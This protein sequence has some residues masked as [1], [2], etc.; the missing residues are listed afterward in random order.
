MSKENKTKSKSWINRFIRTWVFK[1]YSLNFEK[2]R[3]KIFIKFINPQIE[4]KILD[5][6]GSDGRRMIFLASDYKSIVI[7]D[8]S[9]KA[10]IK[11]KETYGYNTVLLIEDEPLPF[12]DKFFD[13]VFCNSV[14]EHI[15]IKTSANDRVSNKEFRER[16]LIKQRKFA[17]EI[18]RVGKRYFVQ[19]P[20]KHFFI[21]SHAWF[22]S[23]IIYLPRRVKI[24]VIRFLN[25]FWI[26]K[27]SPDLNL[28]TKREMK[29]LFPECIQLKE[30]SLF[31]TKSLISIKN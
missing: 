14:I 1:P 16:S 11:A 10:L 29:S 4:D 17:D 28:L 12:P 27:T 18:R 23:I 7:A 9:E 30:K 26:K 3:E 2:H 22:P 13:V 6:G 31:M 25:Q 24:K 19:T 5:L 21:E 20:Y 8:T 15:T